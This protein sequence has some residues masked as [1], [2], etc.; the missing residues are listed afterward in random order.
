[1]N[2]SFLTTLLTLLC[3]VSTAQAGDGTLPVIRSIN[4]EFDQGSLR[5][6]LLL[7]KCVNIKIENMVPKTKVLNKQFQLKKAKMEQK[8]K[9]RKLNGLIDIKIETKLLN[10]PVQ[11]SLLN[12]SESQFQN[13]L[14][15]AHDTLIQNIQLNT[16]GIGCQSI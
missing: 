8:I 11:S 7:P 5:N 12:L 4:I 2:K 9:I 15:I 16:N 6:Q 1:M 3:L 10:R 14:E 13:Q